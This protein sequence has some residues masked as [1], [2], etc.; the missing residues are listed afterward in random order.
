MVPLSIGHGPF[1]AEGLVATG[2]AAVEAKTSTLVHHK[3]KGIGN[4]LVARPRRQG[5]LI[6]AVGVHP[7]LNRKRSIPTGRQARGH[8][9]GQ[10]GGGSL[11]IDRSVRAT[12][13]GV[14]FNPDL[15]SQAVNGPK[16]PLPE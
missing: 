4:G 9:Q 10:G 5:H 14:G 16:L 3:F 8:L 11:K 2:T 1:S 7:K 15:A 13:T 12:R 6:E